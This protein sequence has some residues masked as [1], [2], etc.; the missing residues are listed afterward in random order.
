[1]PTNIADVPKNLMSD[2]DLVSDPEMMRNPQQRMTDALVNDGRDI[3]L[4]Y[5]SDAADEV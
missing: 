1:M 2:F 4:L 3:C 5:T